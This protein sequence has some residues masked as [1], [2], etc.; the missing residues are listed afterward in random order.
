MPSNI[1]KLN[2][3]FLCGS[4]EPCKDGV[5]DYTFKL[6]CELQKLGHN[7]TCISLYDTHLCMS[8]SSTPF[9]SVKGNVNIYRFD[10]QSS[11][12][13]KVLFIKRLLKSFSKSIISLQYVPYSFGQ[14]GIPIRLA[15]WL[16][17][18][19]N[20]FC[21]HIM[22]HEVWI[23]HRKTIKDTIIAIN[24]KI[25][26]RFLLFCLRPKVIHT[27]NN[28][29]KKMLLSIGR[30]SSVLPLVSHIDFQQT[31]NQFTTSDN[32]WNFLLFGSVHEDWDHS[33][34]FNVI[35]KA[36]D[37]HNIRL[38]N[39]NLIGN[40]GE[41]G[42]RLWKSLS[43]NSSSFFAFK[44]FGQ[45]HES[46]ISY[47]LQAADFGVTTTP[48]HLIEKSSS[49]AAMLSHG[50]PV[51]I[52]RISSDIDSNLKL[53]NDSKFLLVDKDFID[54]IVITKHFK[55][56]NSLRTTVDLFLDSLGG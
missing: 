32:E 26:L 43:D 19:G 15:L 3:F 27:S 33:L 47:H 34:F 21:W 25:L 13:I 49:V 41:Y 39:F 35:D 22:F 40:A 31:T 50:L 48:S 12:L 37:I 56:Y 11:W 5:G 51:I 53:R 16:P 23:E 55:P 17:L 8:S 36:R 46:S 54:K 14:S 28:I 6:A 7:C 24:Q 2:I 20:T 9:F 30:R 18:L 29:Y 1:I 10:S 38:C 44:F 42:K 45:L 52:P 4:L